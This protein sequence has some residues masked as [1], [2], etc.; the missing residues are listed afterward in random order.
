MSPAL[1]RLANT[2]AAA[3]ED[4]GTRGIAEMV[5]AGKSSVARWG[6]DL[7]AWSATALLTLAQR[8]DEVRAAVLD[9]L[10]G[11]EIRGRAGDATRD[12][13]GVLVAGNKALA[14]LSADLADGSLSPAEARARLPELRE[15]IAQLRRLVL[16]AEAIAGAG[17][18]IGSTS[19][20]P[21]TA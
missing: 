11:T 8:D 21:R 9:L 12:G 2:V 14:N 4:H 10:A 3:V 7:G 16:D 15:C 6:D 1:S 20:H 17:G 19:H 13:F 18:Q 5:G